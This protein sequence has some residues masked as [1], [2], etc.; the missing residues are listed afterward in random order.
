M[1]VRKKGFTLIELLVVIAI[2]AILAAILFPVFA[3]ARAQARKTSCLSNVKQL[4]LSIAMYTQDY[5]ETLPLIFSAGSFTDPEVFYPFGSVPTASWHNLV[6]PYIKNWQLSICPDS[7][8]TQSDPV[9]F[10]DPFLNFGMPP[11]SAIHGKAQWGDRYYSQGQQVYWQGVGGS[12][13]DS[14]WTEGGYTSVNTP[15][16]GLAGIAVPAN[17]TLVSDAAQPD[18][19]AN[20]FTPGSRD[21]NFFGTCATFGGPSY[22]YG[23]SPRHLKSTDYCNNLATGSGQVVVGFVD[24]H[25]KSFA[26]GQYFR[27]RPVSGNLNV[28][29]YLWPSE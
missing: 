20:W 8:M 6:K 14:G 29:Q 9:N 4:T 15:S 16:S 26:T 28:Y 11:L 2:I 23:P 7:Q 27:T 18:W 3:Q 13:G 10:Y 25:A 17:M 24:G 21:L 12:F 5:D 19:S 22:R 1:F